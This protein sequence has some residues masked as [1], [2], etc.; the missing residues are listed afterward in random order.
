MKV[1]FVIFLEQI[2]IYFLDNGELANVAESAEN[3]EDAGEG[4]GEAGGEDMIFSIEADQDFSLLSTLTQIEKIAMPAL[5][6]ASL[7]GGNLFLCKNFL[8]NILFR[9]CSWNI[10]WRYFSSW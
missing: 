10:Y 1:N 4:F 6:V 3:A 7:V 5:A 9:S 2:L 8:L